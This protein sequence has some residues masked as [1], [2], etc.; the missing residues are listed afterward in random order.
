M[1]LFKSEKEIK[2]FDLEKMEIAKF[3]NLHLIKGGSEGA[4]IDP[5]NKSTGTCEEDQ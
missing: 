5:K 1:K 2:K 3:E 4:P